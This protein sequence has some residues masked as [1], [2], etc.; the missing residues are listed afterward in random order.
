MSYQ[1]TQIHLK[2]GGNPKG[3]VSLAFTLKVRD[4]VSSTLQSDVRGNLIY[5]ELHGHEM[6]ASI[7]LKPFFR[8]VTGKNIARLSYMLLRIV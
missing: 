4:F 5:A 8:G 2:E 6:L 7:F 3:C 1:N